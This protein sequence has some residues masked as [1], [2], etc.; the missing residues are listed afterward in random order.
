M[1]K[2]EECKEKTIYCLVESLS[3]RNVKS[4]YEL[5]KH[6]CE[7]N[8]HFLV[9]LY[10]EATK[11]FFEESP[12]YAFYIPYYVIISSYYLKRPD[13]AIQM[14]E[15][16][17][18]YHYH[19]PSF[20]MN[21]LSSNAKFY[22]LSAELLTSFQEYIHKKSIFFYVGP[23]FFPWNDTYGKTHA[24]GGSEQAVRYLS[25]QFP[26][27]VV[28]VCGDVIEETIKNVHYVKEM[29]TIHFEA[30]IVSR[31]L[32]FF[33]KYPTH[34]TNRILL[35]AHDTTFY[36]V[37]DVHGVLKKWL[38]FIKACVCLSPYHEELFSKE[39]P[40]LPLTTI[41][42]GI[43]PSLFSE[44]TKHPNRFI[45][46][47]RSERGLA[48]LLRL[49][50][51]ILEK[52]PDSTLVISSYEPFPKEQDEHLLPLHS[53][54]Q[55]VGKLSPTE[56]YEEM[57]VA[58]YWLFPSDFLETS[59]ITA[60]EMMATK[61][62][63]LYYPIGGLV[64]TMGGY[65]IKMTRGKEL[66][67]LDESY[68]LDEAK[69]YAISC[70]WENRAIE[71]KQ[72]IEPPIYNPSVPHEEPVHILLTATL[73]ININKTCMFQ[74]NKTDRKN[75]YLKS[76]K[77]WLEITNLN[78]TLV[79]NSMDDFPELEKIKENPRFEYITYDEKKYKDAY[80]CSS[81]GISELFAIRYAYHHSERL[82]KANYI[83]K[84]TARY[85]IPELESYLKSIKLSDY[86]CLVQHDIDR[87]EMVGARHDF[88][89]TVFKY[90]TQYDHIEDYYKS[91]ASSLKRLVC[92]KFFIEPTQRGG[93]NEIFTTI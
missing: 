31:N 6:Y 92:K 5:I 13:I 37:S 17:V 48:T 79:E 74:L 12:W 9:I 4:A 35:M 78:I 83:I 88:F 42:N 40:Y 1:E 20:F 76:I 38:S 73:N 41:N 63:C 8:N 90:S 77:N 30:I 28:Y 82:Q 11:D 22:D 27:Y 24:L 14:Y 57:A 26:E 21:H 65:G 93:E 61:V 53:S 19:G 45:F 2:Y 59:C 52:R 84:I 64:D 68:D 70:S 7:K 55:H 72:I 54:I 10:Y 3:S 60:L 86:E 33:E 58:E 39:Y 50:P 66:D 25:K 85:F 75:A 62:K 23:S 18:K 16:I 67:A 43:E 46:T 91:T 81:K 51:S 80:D 71:W 69:E 15:R 29:P 44:K 49:W 89:D 56:L 34:D 47:S 36:G 32:S 87:C